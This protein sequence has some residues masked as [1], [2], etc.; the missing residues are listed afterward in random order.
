M[1]LWFYRWIKQCQLV[2]IIVF[3]LLSNV[4]IS[5]WYVYLFILY[6]SFLF[7]STF[8]LIDVGQA[9]KFH[10]IRLWSWKIPDCTFFSHCAVV[11]KFLTVN[12]DT[13]PCILSWLLLPAAWYLWSFPQIFAYSAPSKWQSILFQY[14]SYVCSINC[15]AGSK[16]MYSVQRVRLLVDICYVSSE[17]CCYVYSSNIW[18]AVSSCILHK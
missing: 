4:A 3:C 5:E 11:P 13:T 10:Q 6:F 7:F 8:F 18:G 16:A 12:Q 15:T 17:I 9:S 1:Y 2:I 14:W